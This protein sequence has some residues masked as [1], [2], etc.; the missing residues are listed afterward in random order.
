MLLCALF[1]ASCVSVLFFA[2]SKGGARTQTYRHMYL[3]PSVVCCLL[4]VVCYLLSCVCYQGGKTALELAG[5]GLN[6][7]LTSLLTSAISQRGRVTPCSPVPPLLRD[8]TLSPMFL[9]LTTTTI[10]TTVTPMMPS[11]AYIFQWCLPVHTHTCTWHTAT[12]PGAYLNTRTRTHT[13]KDKHTDTRTHTLKHTD[14]RTHTYTHYSSVGAAPLTSCSA[15]GNASV[16]GPCSCR[17]CSDWL[18]IRA[19]VCCWVRVVRH[20]G[21]HHSTS[22]H[23]FAHHSTAQHSM[24]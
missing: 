12:P 24:T 16:Y 19:S 23:V 7:Q 2:C 14:T 17:C 3:L 10:A 1:A 18:A 13:H 11:R 20:N 9:A 8:L 15:K 5:D 21:T 4:Y 22:Q 6:G